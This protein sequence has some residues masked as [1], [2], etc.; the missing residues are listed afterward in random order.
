ML[1]YGQTYFKNLAMFNIM[2]PFRTYAKFSEELT[3]ITLWYAYVRV[4]QEG[5][6][7]VFR[8]ILRKS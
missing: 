7:L 1:K 2:H 5:E 4:Y 3:F 8:N 6:I